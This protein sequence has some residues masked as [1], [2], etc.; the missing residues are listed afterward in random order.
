MAEGNRPVVRHISRTYAIVL[1]I[2][3]E[4]YQQLNSTY[5][6]GVRGW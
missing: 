3:S 4:G 5:R 1:G 6:N 2:R